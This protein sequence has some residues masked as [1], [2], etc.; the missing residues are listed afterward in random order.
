MSHPLVVA[1]RGGELRCRG[2]RQESILRM[3]ENN[4]EIGERPEDLVIYAG[5]G[6]AAR[7]WASYHEIV[8]ALHYLG[9]DETLVIQSGKPVGIWQTQRAAPLV[10]MAN[11]N[12]TAG[13][14]P[15]EFYALLDAGLTIWPGM[16]AA[17]WQ[18]IGPQGI[19]QGTYESFTAAG[20][21]YFGGSLAGR[22][23]LTGGC[24]GMGGAQPM[25][26]KLAGASILVA[27]VNEERLRRRQDSGYLDEYTTDLSVA[28]DRWLA[29]A[30][31]GETGSVGVVA[32]VVEV[33]ETL[34]A[35][36]MTPDIVTDQT[37]TD[38]RDGSCP[39]GLSASEAERLRVE[40][41]DEL[42]V[43]ARTTLAR[44]V[45]AMLEFRRRGAVV[46]EYGNWLRREALRAGVD[47][48]M[49]I[50]SF[51]TQFIRPM[52]CEAIGPFRWIAISGSE[53]T[54]T[55]IDSLLTEMF[56]DVP[57]VTQ[58]LAKAQSLAFTG[59]PARICWLGHHERTRAALAVNELIGSGAISGPV[60]FTRDHL[61]AGS[62]SIPERET[63][64]MLDGSD[65][66]ADW[67]LLNAML[68]GA[69]GA[70]LI[71]L[72]GLAGRS[73]SAG[74]TLIADG[75]ADAAERIERVLEADTG[76]GIL[77]YAD[78][79]YGAATAAA[80]RDGLGIERQLA[81]RRAADGRAATQ[82]P[83]RQAPATQ[84]PATH[85]AP[86]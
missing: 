73:Q 76:L 38:P 59:L 9:E 34:L 82:A 16:T 55:R 65:A 6:K 2:W 36:R 11:G 54:I 60:A 79:G 66:I 28:I 49:E 47:D 70:D 29:T 80:E 44:H 30:R 53:T 74:V 39:I 18:Y 31:G 20:R 3:L 72:H 4:L 33:M 86:A 41:P 37:T 50:P 52:F 81:V 32:N 77:R 27:E 75:S 51:V 25:A 83:A 67:A 57:R 15:E 10:V 62:A 24:G 48:A 63:E 5:R 14:S 7:D 78:A 85:R 71:A 45:R 8:E 21:T 35:R 46:F 43:L 23:I 61:D 22:T 84:A 17:A 58:W 19:V 26:G 69:A 12:V 40:D 42:V 68:N 64:A 13:P 56:T 1:G